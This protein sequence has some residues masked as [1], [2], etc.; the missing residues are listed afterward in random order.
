MLLYLSHVVREHAHDLYAFRSLRDKKMF[1]MLTQVKGVGPKSAYSLVMA[2]GAHAV[3]QAV[4]LE[5]K[6]QL[7]KAHGVGLKAASQIILDLAKN[8]HKIRMYSDKPCTLEGPTNEMPGGKDLET[9][10]TSP[11]DNILQ[12]ALLAC[13][14]LGLREEHIIPKASTF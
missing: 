13:R 2:L 1:E 4:A 5:D 10:N 8:I 11:S 7:A 14:E 3:A 12:E 9:P 6:G